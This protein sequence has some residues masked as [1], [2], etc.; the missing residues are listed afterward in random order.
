M[1]QGNNYDIQSI[2]IEKQEWKGK[3]KLESHGSGLKM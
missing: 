1:V 2:R 3:D